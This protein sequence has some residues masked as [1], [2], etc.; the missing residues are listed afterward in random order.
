MI[1][2]ARQQA[3]R[4]GALASV[5]IIEAKPGSTNTVSG[6]VKFSLD[7]RAAKDETVERMEQVLKDQFDVIADGTHGQRSHDRV[8]VKWKQDSTSPAVNFH[9]DCINCVT[10]AVKDTFGDDAEKLSK[11]MVSGAGH[12][13]VYTSKRVPTCMI[14]VPSRGGISHNPE[15][16]TSPEDCALGAEILL[17]AVLGYDKLRKSRSEVQ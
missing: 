8:Q 7:I 10:D 12:D 11:Q 14:F 9:E 1:V 17:K 16:Y 6:E 15:E 2:E 4:H 13:S 3:V 5:G